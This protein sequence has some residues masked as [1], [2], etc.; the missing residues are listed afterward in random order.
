MISYKYHIALLA[1]SMLVSCQKKEEPQPKEEVFRLEAPSNLGEVPFP[2]SNE[3][4]EQKIELG[5]ML[6]YD[7]VLSGNNQ[8]SCA[9]CHLQS[10]AFTDGESLTSKGVS[11]KPLLRHSPAL[12]N[13]AWMRGLFWE[14]GAKNLESLSLGP[15]SHSDEMDQSI[16]ELV[17]EV[18]AIPKY[19]D[20][21]YQAYGIQEIELTHI[22]Q[23]LAQ[24]QRTL[25]SAN[26]KYDKHIRNE[27]GVR[28]NSLELKGLQLYESKCSSCHSSDLFTDNDYHNNG[29]DSVWNDIS[30]EYIFTGRY[31]ISFDSA[32]LGKYKTP[33]LRNVAL[34][35]PY[36]HDGR[37]QSLEDVLEHYNSGIKLSPSLDN[38]LFQNEGKA[39]IPLSQEEREALIAFLNSL[40]DFEFLSEEK[41]SNPN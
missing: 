3:F 36:M 27:D 14:G 4:T 19:R 41:F 25:I 12:I 30:H 23:V 40:S 24:F 28:L 7:P 31:R 38:A 22:L 11:G 18:N 16:P 8:V 26:S 32:D 13:L 39:G 5:R 9:T 37:F 1:I 10:I 20:G 33:T 21:F 6:F 34:T 2:E 29:I 15:I 35:A 17:E